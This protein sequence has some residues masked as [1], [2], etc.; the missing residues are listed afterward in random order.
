MRCQLNQ[1][2]AITRNEAETNMKKPEEYAKIVIKVPKKFAEFC[3]SEEIKEKPYDV[4]QM[5]SFIPDSCDG[6]R[7]DGM[8]YKRWAEWARDYMKRNQIVKTELAKKCDIPG[9]TL[10]HAI[11]GVGYDVRAET[12]TKITNALLGIDHRRYPCHMAALLMA[13][14]II[15]DEDNES[16]IAELQEEIQRLGSDLA[17]AKEK[18]VA[19]VQEAKQEAQVKIDYLKAQIETRDKFLDEKN[20]QINKLMDK[21]LESK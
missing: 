11:S 2:F 14:Q 10:S 4:C 16:K 12:R 5:C 9:S 21:L 20:V 13:G 15:D 17:H 6:P 8:E 7:L 19:K 3:Q 1:N 18:A